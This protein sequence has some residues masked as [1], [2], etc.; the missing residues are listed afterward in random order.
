MLTLTGYDADDQVLAQE[1]RTYTRW[2]KQDNTVVYLE[3][4]ARD[5]WKQCYVY[6]WG[7]AENASWP[8]TKAELTDQGL[9]R[10]ILPYPFEIPGSNGNVIF[11]DGAGN[12]FDAGAIAPGQQKVYTSSGVWKDYRAEDYTEP[13][14][15]L[16]VPSG[17]LLIGGKLPKVFLRNC[18]RASYRVVINGEEGSARTGSLN[19]GDELPLTGLA[20]LDE[21]EVTLVGYVGENQAATSSFSYTAWEKQ[22]NT[23]IYMEQSAR[24]AWE[25]CNTYIWG[26]YENAGWP[27]VE[28]EKIAGDIYKLVLPY[29]YEI[30]DS[31]GNVIFNNGSGEQF[32]AGRITPGQKL[33]YT[34]DDKWIAYEEPTAVLLGDADGDGDVTILDATAIQRKLA[35]LSTEFV[36][37]AADADG[38]SEL[39][40]LDATAIQRYLAGLS[41]NE[42]IGKPV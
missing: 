28:M 32:D 35:A 37:A 39:T 1:S 24:P 34:A 8:G 21:V 27:G 42:N 7:S 26:S 19:A 11:N 12:Q 30:P 29:Q 18:D 3:P 14:V 23:V 38:D 5:E 16:S 25:K 33:I 41:S 17:Y 6:V 4:E 2:I 36:E 9:Y 22:N 31:Y 20:H 10:Y 13:S 40:I 15:K